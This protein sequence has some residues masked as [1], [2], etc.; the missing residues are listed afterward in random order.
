[1]NKEKAVGTLI[2]LMFTTFVIGIT[3]NAIDKNETISKLQKDINFKNELLKDA[4]DYYKKYDEIII[5]LKKENKKLK[6]QVKSKEV[7]FIQTNGK[8]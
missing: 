8:A 7:F 1:M 3:I 5:D 2:F 6:K 4:N